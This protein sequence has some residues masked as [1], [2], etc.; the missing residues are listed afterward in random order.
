M[1]MA[2]WLQVL[3]VVLR[4]C[5]VLA[6]PVLIWIV[7]TIRKDM[8]SGLVTYGVFQSHVDKVAN[9]AQLHASRVVQVEHSVDMLKLEMNHR[10]T[11]E[12]FNKVDQKVVTIGSEV[13][14]MMRQV[15]TVAATVVRIED[16][17]LDGKS[18]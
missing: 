5:E 3:D 4:V 17:L 6:V 7:K 16:F 10:P 2:Q 15:E 14:A 13:K 1:T 9:I 12:D 8:R 18:R 11:K